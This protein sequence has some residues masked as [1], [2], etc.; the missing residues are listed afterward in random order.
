MDC[1]K[2]SEIFA[3]QASRGAVAKIN[4][5]PTYALKDERAAMDRSLL[6]FFLAMN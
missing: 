5:W 6:I 3:T 2:N 4:V 1:L